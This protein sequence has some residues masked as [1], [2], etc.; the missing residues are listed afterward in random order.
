MRYHTGTKNTTFG[1]NMRVEVYRNLHTG[2]M[3]VREAGGRVLTHEDQ[4]FLAN[5]RFVVQP[6]GRERVR[7]EGKKNVHAF[8]RG[9]LRGFSVGQNLGFDNWQQWEEATYNP[10]KYDSFVAKADE[11]P[12]DYASRAVVTTRGVY[13][14][15]SFESRAFDREVV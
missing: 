12:L 5:P 14:A 11:T 9:E 8:V 10:Y 13:F 2:K 15:R 1:C 4:V 7:R 3:S 6:A